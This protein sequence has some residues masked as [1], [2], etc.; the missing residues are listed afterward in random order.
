LPPGL[1]HS[2]YIKDDDYLESYSHGNFITLTNLS[3]N[4]IK[5]IIKFKIEPLHVSIHSFN[6]EIRKILFCGIK[7][8][9]APA[10]F[11]ELD[12]NK[13]RTNVQ[14]V[15]C[16]GINDGADLVNSLEILINDFKNVLSVGIVPVGITK[17]S[18][19]SLLRSYRRSSCSGLIDFIE[20]FKNS[21]EKN[22]ATGKI[23]LSDEF[24]II[25]GRP[26][27][28]YAAYGKFLQIQNGIGKSRDFLNDIFL[29]LKKTKPGAISLQIQSANKRKKLIITS[30]YGIKV[31]EQAFNAADDFLAALGLQKPA[32]YRLMAVKNE[33]LGG[34]V[35][36]TGLLSGQDILNCLKKVNS[37][38]YDDILVPGCIFNYNSKT[39]DDY[40][41]EDILGFCGNIKIVPEDG[42]SFAESL[43]CLK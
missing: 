15:L 21:Y 27:P 10:R 36:V 37:T 3:E 39:L 24:Y 25:S 4:D 40:S 34:N 20:D 32:G 23:F 12:D 9:K 38:A 26:L 11:K 17:Y 28:G 7:D 41:P 18:K 43:L 19:N 16:P 22:N 13:I 14:I 8:D 31:L 30:E 2:L 35:K 6:P 42:K 29:K 33:F 5:K 1:R